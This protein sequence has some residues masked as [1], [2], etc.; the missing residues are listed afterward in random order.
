MCLYKQIHVYLY[1]C[2]YHLKLYEHV[3]LNVWMLSNLQGLISQG[4]RTSNEARSPVSARSPDFPSPP[5]PT[6]IPLYTDRSSRTVTDGPSPANRKTPWDEY[7]RN[8]LRDLQQKNAKRD[9]FLVEVT[10]F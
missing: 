3:F 10:I 9:L 2:I 8:Y 7:Q 5:R 4:R 1:T 6:D